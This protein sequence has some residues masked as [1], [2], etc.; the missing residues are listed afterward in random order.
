MTSCSGVA[1]VE[2]SPISC[3]AEEFSLKHP[4]YPALIAAGRKEIKRQ[5]LQ[6]NDLPLHLFPLARI[7]TRGRL[8]AD[9]SKVLEPDAAIIADVVPPCTVAVRRFLQWMQI[10]LFSDEDLHFAVVPKSGA[11]KLL[12]GVESDHPRISG[13]DGYV[14]H[15]NGSSPIVAPRSQQEI[16]TTISCCSVCCGMTTSPATTSC[17][18]KSYENENV[19]FISYVSQRAA[20]LE[21]AQ[22]LLYCSELLGRPQLVADTVSPRKDG[23]LWRKRD[24]ILN[25]WIHCIK[26]YT[27][28]FVYGEKS[29]LLLNPNTIAAEATHSICRDDQIWIHENLAVMPSSLGGSG[30]FVKENITIPSQTVLMSV[31]EQK[32][33]NLYAALQDSEFGV[34]AISLLQPEILSCIDADMIL[35]LFIVFDRYGRRGNKPRFQQYYESVPDFSNGLAHNLMLAPP[36]VIS[37]LEIPAIE[38]AVDSLSDNLFKSLQWCATHVF[39]KF[40]TLFPSDVATWDHILWAR[41]IIDTRGFALKVPPSSSSFVVVTTPEDTIE[42][43]TDNAT[44]WTLDYAGTTRG[45][46]RVTVPQRLTTLIPGVDQF[47]HDPLVATCRP[48]QFNAVSRRFE[49]RSDLQFSNST[50]QPTEIFMSYGPCETWQLLLH[51]GFCPT[52]RPSFTGLVPSRYDMLHNANIDTLT[53]DI[54]VEEDVGHGPASGLQTIGSYQLRDPDAAHPA[55]TPLLAALLEQAYGCVYTGLAAVLEPLVEQTVLKIHILQTEATLAP[56]N[57]QHWFP[58][59]GSRLLCFFECRRD[60]IL[61]HLRRPA[62]R[63][64]SSSA[65]HSNALSLNETC[66]DKAASHDDALDEDAL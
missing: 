58:I 55:V 7:N 26:Q 28:Q 32:T 62:L 48:P 47:N 57:Q 24:E 52:P 51:Y 35:L 15:R 66:A 21:A 30:V 6:E 25:T 9:D 27:Y 12:D 3:S 49:V 45:V 1:P 36:E 40:E 11:T 20:L 8:H 56:A 50:N 39:P 31:D 65:G 38:D 54:E 46:S 60:F 59:W 16:L 37:F 33:I 4:S 5:L 42:S 22:K 19:G 14:V 34:V 23:L 13:S 53:L 2:D 10:W 29:P 43:C 17:C 44:T 18:Q 63:H 61:K 64:L 41:W